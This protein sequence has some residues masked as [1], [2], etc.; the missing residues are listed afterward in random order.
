MVLDPAHH[1]VRSDLADIRLADRIFAPHYALA[2][3]RFATC[4]VAVRATRDAHS[5]VLGMLALGD[6]FEV[7]E[8]SRQQAW[9]SATAA[10]LVGYV[11][12]DCLSW[13]AP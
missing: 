11:D 2:V 3:A 10:Q 8:F 5:P 9:G 4:P 12:T 1:A 13:V 7:L 6:V